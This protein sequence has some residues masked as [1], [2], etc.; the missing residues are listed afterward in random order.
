VG[1]DVT[2]VGLTSR[3]GLH[4]GFLSCTLGLWVFRRINGVLVFSLLGGTL[5]LWVFC[6]LNGV[7]VFSWLGGTLGLW[8]FCRLN[9]VLVFSLLGGTLGLWVFSFLVGVATD[10]LD[11]CVGGEAVGVTEGSFFFRVLALIASS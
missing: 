10:D 5:G 11:V 8:V 6:R 2:A 3:K 7:L 9:G 1:V 4:V